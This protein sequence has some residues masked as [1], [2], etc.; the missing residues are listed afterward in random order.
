[1]VL[2]LATVNREPHNFHD[3]QGGQVRRIGWSNLKNFGTIPERGRKA[4]AYPQVPCMKN[5]TDCRLDDIDEAVSL[6]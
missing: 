1:M 6:A 3:G 2:A 4:A 5:E